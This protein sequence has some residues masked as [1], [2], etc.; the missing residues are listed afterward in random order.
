MI[1]VLWFVCFYGLNR[2]ALIDL[3]DEG[4][5]ANAARQMIETGD[6]VTP[7]LGQGVFLDKPPLTFWF[8][9][10]FIRLLG[11]TPLAARLPSAIAAFLTALSLFYWA[12]RKG[13]MRAGMLAA[14]IY[15]LC[16]LVAVGLARVAMV[17][18]LLTFCFTLAIIGW[19]EGYNGNRKGYLLMA[20]G[21]GLAV[22]T[23]G[24]IGF[25]LPCMA[26]FVWLLVRRDWN[27]LKDVPWIA[28]LSLFML[29]VVPWHLAAWRA[30]GD[31]FFREYIIH[32]H[33]QRFLGQDFGHYRPF[34][35][36]IPV[37]AVSMFPWTAFMPVAWWR[38]LRSVSSEKQSINAMMAMWGVWA[39]I[40][41]LF[42]SISTNKLSSYI[43]PALPA[44]A[45]VSAWRLDGAWKVRKGLTAAESAILGV[46][47]VVPGLIFLT[48]GVLG[49]RWRNPPASPSWLARQLGAIFNWKE[50]SHSTELLWR[51]LTPLTDLAPYWILLGALLLVTSIVILA[52]WRSTSKT[53]VCAV[54][55]SLSVLTL[56]AHLLLPAWSSY[57]A[58]PLNTLGQRT[59]PALQ[60]GE[61]LVLY[62]LHPKRISLHYMLGHDSQI[63]ETFSPEILQNVFRA[64]RHGYILTKKDSALPPL[65]GTLKQE[66]AAGQWALWRYDK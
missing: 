35:N 18:S 13:L 37:L 40:V 57:E 19:I 55:M 51:K 30:N 24:A 27:S 2:V 15:I 8:Q 66:A 46:C 33:V 31:L 43:L 29:L 12:K 44:L 60:R 49:W 23:K 20:S 62:E 32:Q 3:I 42:F 50:Q 25:L 39:A 38:S 28:S 7:R 61:H 34:W 48:A 63:V 16:P 47:G 14:V 41:V 9:S 58:V 17:D 21:M 26:A 56:T 36:Y 54:L 64:H 6:W 1:L 65:P 11:A 5:Y 52:F 45:L 4:L 53:F 59:L 22:L 10:I